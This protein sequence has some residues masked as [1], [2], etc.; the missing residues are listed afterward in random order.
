MRTHARPAPTL[1]PTLPP[2]RPHRRRRPP[3]TVS[4]FTGIVQ[5]TAV[6]DAVTA[7]SPGVKSLAVRFPAG[8]LAGVPLG[9]SVAVDGTCLTVVGVD[10]GCVARFDVVDETL[11][12]TTL[13]RLAP[14]DA[15][16]YERSAR[17]GDEVG[18]HVVSGHVATQARVSRVD[19]AADGNVAVTLT[20]ADGAWAR[21]ILPKGFVAVAGVSLTVGAVA[22]HGPSAAH[23]GADFTV[24][25]IPETLR[26]TVLGALAPGDAVNIEVDAAAQAVVAAVDAALEER[27]D[28]WVSGRVE[29]VVRRVVA[30]VVGRR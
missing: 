18:G 22:R 8:A 20:V 5:G 23:A 11:R 30:E 19:R 6:V 29:E 17:V 3:P 16:N 7:P 1:A 25:L 27:L 4:M 28:G 15:V 2:A 24:H 12:V 9:G 21:Y 10:D 13:G 26:A 14:G